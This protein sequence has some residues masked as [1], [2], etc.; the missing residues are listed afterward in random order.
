MD[1]RHAVLP[2]VAVDSVVEVEVVV[3][4]LVV[5]SDLRMEL[6]GRRQNVNSAVAICN[7]RC[8]SDPSTLFCSSPKVFN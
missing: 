6:V 7:C 8:K 3:V 2:V 5:R 1:L 4:H